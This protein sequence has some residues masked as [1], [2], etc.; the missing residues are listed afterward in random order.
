MKEIL[1]DGREYLEQLKETCEREFPHYKHDI[2]LTSSIML[3]NY[4]RSVIS[5][6]ACNT[7][8]KTQRLTMDEILKELNDANDNNIVK[9]WCKK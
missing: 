5:S 3:V 7:A 4:Q 2:P 1:D 9:V 6:D 8:Q